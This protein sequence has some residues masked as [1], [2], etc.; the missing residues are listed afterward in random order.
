MIV[1]KKE[2]KN[3]T[4]KI[5][6]TDFID[7]GFYVERFE[8]Y[9]DYKSALEELKMEKEIN[10]ADLKTLKLKLNVVP[11]KGEITIKVPWFI[12]IEFEQFENEDDMPKWKNS[13]ETKVPELKSIKSQDGKVEAELNVKPIANLDIEKPLKKSLLAYMKQYLKSLKE[14]MKTTL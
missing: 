2:L 5:F 8:P 7:G 12:N 11:K 1:K 10:I 9:Q 13:Y 3:N 4:F 6:S 14:K